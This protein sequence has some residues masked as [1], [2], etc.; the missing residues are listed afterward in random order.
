[1]AAPFSQVLRKGMKELH[2]SQEM[3]TSSK[4]TTSLYL[5]A[6]A[7]M[8]RSVFLVCKDFRRLAY[9]HQFI[10][11]AL[12]FIREVSI[13]EKGCLH[14]EVIDKLLEVI[15]VAPADI[16]KILSLCNGKTTWELLSRFEIKCRN[17]LVLNL[18]GT[19]GHVPENVITFAQLRKLNDLHV[20]MFAAGVREM[21]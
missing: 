7:C 12:D 21:I 4:K 14:V 8:F 18:S 6:E 19:R 17:L 20:R 5:F 13:G 11:I 1:M 10:K 3:W 15:N 9:D 16:V 2:C